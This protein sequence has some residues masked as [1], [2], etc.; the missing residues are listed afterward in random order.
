M[1]PEIENLSHAVEILKTLGKVYLSKNQYREAAEKFEN[2]IRLGVKDTEA[3]RHLAVA[4]AGQKLYTPEA[5][6][7]YAWAVEKFPQDKTVCLHVAL[8]ALHHGVEDEQAQRFYEAALKFHPAFA[9]DLYLHLHYIFH[10][11]KKYDESFQTLKQAL[12]LEH[13]GEDLLVT[14]LTQLGWHYDRQQELIMTLQFLLGNNEEN[15]TIR[16]CLAF[17][18]AHT[19]IRHHGKQKPSEVNLP[20]GSETDLQM[21][22]AALP[23]PANLTTLDAVRDYCTIQLALHVAP[24]SSK[25]FSAP[26]TLSNQNENY[27]K[28]TPKAFEYRSL[29]NPSPLEE[30]L[31][32]SS[33]ASL[34]PATLPAQPENGVFDWQRDFLKLLPA[35]NATATM[36][37]PADHHANPDHEI[38]ALLVMTPIFSPR[39]SGQ[40]NVPASTPEMTIRKVVELI[41]QHF[42]EQDS[43]MRIYAFNDGLLIFFVD[44][45]KLAAAAIEAFKKIALNNILTPQK[46]QIVLQAALHVSS[47]SVA[48]FSSP[49]ESNLAGM[50]LVYDTLHLL[51]AEIEAPAQQKR[52]KPQDQTEAACSR[53]WMSR[54]IFESVM[55]TEHFVAKNWGPAYWGAPGWHEEVCEIIWHNPLDYAGEKN[56]YTLGRFLVL[57]KFHE[58]RTHSTYRTRDRALERPVVLKALR[59]EIYTRQRSDEAQQTAMISSVRRL[60]RL[61][62]PG[63]AM[64]YDMGSHEDIF[65]YV[66]EYIEGESLAQTLAAKRILPAAEAVRWLIEVC[67]ILRYAHQSGVYHGNLKPANIWQLKASVMKEPI[68]ARALLAPPASQS[69]KITLGLKISDFFIP[70]FNKISA[71]NWHYVAPELLFHKR[72]NNGSALNAAV[73]V[74]AVGMILY[75]CL[76]GENPFNH[77]DFPTTRSLWE[78]TPLAALSAINHHSTD[79]SI[80]AALDEVVQRATHQDPFQRFQTVEALEAALRQALKTPS[81]LIPKSLGLMSEAR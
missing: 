44:Q 71:A 61:E 57:E 18:L 72:V 64:I 34:Q 22:Q 25:N 54:R 39:K 16:R 70:G 75:E 19:I 73:D 29:L 20:Y 7:V 27:L 43:A 77:I 49:E 56:P 30:I 8:A 55:D 80:L 68:H 11:Q 65:Y 2:I 26:P 76:C 4:L 21:L 37:A 42:T 31:S 46:K 41:A 28:A 74:Y 1:P 81:A 24:K 47:R 59:P 15:P 58:Q 32:N 60:G 3:Y 69:E 6:R 63:V 14:R 38:T 5:L 35:G 66:R 12:Y 36:E 9:K 51:Q 62:H 33:S 48:D 50:E 52:G 10:R 45:I 78:Q 40:E 13:S 17:S 53:L 67:R 23:K 79:I